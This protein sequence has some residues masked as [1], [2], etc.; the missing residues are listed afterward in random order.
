MCKRLLRDLLSKIWLDEEVPVEFARATFVMLYKHKGSRDD[1]SKYRCIIGL[2][3]HAY[4]IL[5]I[6]LLQRLEAET[7]G[8]LSDWQAGF[9]K[10]RGCRDHVMT[11]RTIFDDMLEQ[12]RKLYVTFIDYSAA[13]DSVSHKFLDEALKEAGASDKTRSLFRAIYRAASATTKIESTDGETVMSKPFAINRGVIQGDITSPIYFILA[14][15]LIMKRHDKNHNKGIVFGGHRVHTLGYADDAALLD[16]CCDT[17][18]DR[19]TSISTGSRDDA[20]MTINISKTEVMHVQEQGRVAPVTAE[21]ATKACKYTCPN[22]GCNK[23]FFNAHGCKCHA[24]RC[25]FKDHFYVDKLLAVRGST[26]S[27]KREFLVR[28]EGY[29]PEDDTWEPRQN[30]SPKTIKE[31]LLSNGLYD[32]E[33]QGER[34]PHCDKPAMR[35]HTWC[36][37]PPALVQVD[38]GSEAK[39]PWDVCGQQG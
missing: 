17:A 25:K 9:R 37:N 24:G 1:P 19:V 28:W 34:C 3:G 23:V 38:T 36:Q 4:K 21:E 31:F 13:F 11:M 7:G 20:D 18:T 8:H 15:E 2:L 5:N 10:H 22:P 16:N 27:P 12:G 33:W 30:V 29:G 39:L 32:H 14:L 6:C 26:G 35:K